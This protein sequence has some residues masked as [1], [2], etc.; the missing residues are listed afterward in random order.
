LDWKDSQRAGGTAAG[1]TRQEFPMSRPRITI[2]GLG[3]YLATLRQEAGPK[4]ATV[5]LGDVEVVFTEENGP[6]A[7]GEVLA[8]ER[9]WLLRRPDQAADTLVNGVP[10]TAR[11]RYLR[12][13]DVVQCGPLSLQIT[14]AEEAARPSVPGTSLQIQTVAHRS[15]EE[16]LE[17]LGRFDVNRLA[18]AQ[19][20]V[21]LFRAGYHLRHAAALEEFLRSS[22][23]DAVAVLRAQRGCIL[24]AGPDQ[25]TLTPA[26]WV[27]PQGFP[28]R[29]AYS[30]T[31][32]RRAFERSESLLCQDASA[33][34]QG[35][36]S[37]RLKRMASI[38]CA[39]LRSP[40][41]KLGVLHLDRGPLQEPFSE[42][43][44]FLADALAAS[45][46][47]GIESAQLVVGE[48]QLFLQTVTTLARAVELRDH[49]TGN[50]T[51]RV[52]DY[53]LLLAGE[54]GLGADGREQLRIGAPLHDIGKIGVSDAILNKP[55]RLT[56]DEF[57]EMK[58]HTV[59]GA[60]MLEGI[61]GL[62]PVLPIVRHHHEHWDGTGYPDRL[63]GA[64][65]PPLARIVSVADAFDAMTSARPY[66]AAL[67][68]E[69]AFGEIA[70]RGGTQFAP[71]CSQAFLR[72]RPQIEKLSST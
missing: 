33:E 49:Y 50:H 6:P 36:Q 23:A 65:I 61:A 19:H 27:V 56:A 68:L 71:E 13:H 16:A 59:K 64:A 28:S 42:E 63:A 62:G 40:R 39:V 32:A 29:T 53:A 69:Q 48:R 34:S 54:L 57:E 24:L 31:L 67:P 9:G 30:L 46:S 38:I 58:T 17:A 4:R 70:E 52:A 1:R 8:T 41:R 51:Q 44:F 60:A 18:Q 5:R 37:L 15:W 47:A 22:L 66:R 35:V 20:L 11:Q 7:R 72:L 14:G 21:T 3:A 2:S 55:G 45:I 43:E 12:P 25:E 10:V 26:T